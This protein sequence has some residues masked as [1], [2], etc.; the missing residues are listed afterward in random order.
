MAKTILGQEVAVGD[1]VV[2]CYKHEEYEP[3]SRW[4]GTVVAINDAI[5]VSPDEWSREKPYTFTLDGWEWQEDWTKDTKKYS[6]SYQERAYCTCC[7]IVLLDAKSRYS[8]E[9]RQANRDLGSVKDGTVY[10]PH[11]FI[12]VE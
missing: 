1:K 7:G 4:L 8:L 9:V 6:K 2:Y 11:S 10:D 12:P 3:E 5:R